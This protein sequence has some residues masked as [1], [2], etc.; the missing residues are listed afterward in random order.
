VEPLVVGSTAARSVRCLGRPAIA[1][2]GCDK[3][4]YFN[5]THEAQLEVIGKVR[6]HFGDTDPSEEECRPG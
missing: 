6:G 5:G 3:E 2:S 1:P 4:P